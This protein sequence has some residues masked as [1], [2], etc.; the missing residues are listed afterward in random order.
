ML[1]NT[2]I[3]NN[4]LANNN[5]SSSYQNVHIHFNEDGYVDNSNV[6]TENVNET[7]NI[8]GLQEDMSETSSTITEVLDYPNNTSAIMNSYMD[9]EEDGEEEEQRE[10]ESVS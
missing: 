4:L 2:V 8:V 9:E 6:T 1:R 7:E 10:T 5:S 3:S